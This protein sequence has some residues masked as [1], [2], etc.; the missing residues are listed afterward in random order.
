[1]LNLQVGEHAYIIPY[2]RVVV[3][4]P[5]HYYSSQ[6]ITWH[7]S[8]HGSMKYSGVGS[9]R[10]SIDKYG[11][12]RIRS[13]RMHDQGEWNCMAGSQSASVVLNA[14]TPSA[15]F[16]DWI[17]RNKLWF[18]GMQSDDPKD[19]ATAHAIVQWVEGPWS[20]CSKTCGTTGQQYRVVRC[21]RVDVRFYEIL[22][23]QVCLDK[24]LP[25]PISKR[26]CFKSKGC[27]TWN[28][29]GLDESVVSYCIIIGSFCINRFCRIVNPGTAK[30]DGNIQKILILVIG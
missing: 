29:V 11:R 6:E 16:H 17:Q 5:V 1:M 8:G 13:F 4:C 9:D 26:D 10:I 14:R 15:G 19:L 18:K 24:L 2:T 12:L 21:E 7:H 30:R 28:I 23:D 22:D 20:A 3:R 25:K 27:P